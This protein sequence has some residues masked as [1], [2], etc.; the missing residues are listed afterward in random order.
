[1][2]HQDLIV[3]GYATGSTYFYRDI[4]GREIRRIKGKPNTLA[5]LGVDMYGNLVENYSNTIQIYSGLNYNNLTD[6]TYFVS[7]IKQINGFCYDFDNGLIVCAYD[8]ENICYIYDCSSMNIIPYPDGP[9]SWFRII[10]DGSFIFPY[11]NWIAVS[12]A[13]DLFS[14]KFS[15][16]SIYIYSGLSAVETG[17]FKV[18]NTQGAQITFNVSGDLIEAGINTAG[19][20]YIHN[21]SLRTLKQ[22]I[23]LPGGTI[24]P[25][26]VTI[27]RYVTT[28]YMLSGESGLQFLTTRHP[29]ELS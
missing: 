1:M 14:S 26:N 3:G 21:G 4:S 10:P 27:D 17:R 12:P 22:T 13:G 29:Y 7:G 19:N 15:A 8:W 5:S 24:Q 16:G 28:Q 20:I 2:L 25:I 18:Q 9:T 6:K 23:T 11:A